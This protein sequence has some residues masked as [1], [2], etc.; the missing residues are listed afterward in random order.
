MKK[1]TLTLLILLAVVGIL[2]VF[3]WNRYNALVS[4]QE[5]MNNAWAQ[6]ES[7]YQRRLDLIPNLVSTVKGYATHE[8]QTL[9][10]VTEARSQA[11]QA[12]LSDTMSEEQMAA[13]Q[14]AQN[15]VSHS[16]K[17]VMEAYPELKANEN[18]RALQD[19]LAGTENRIAVARNTFN[20]Q[21]TAY[22]K[23][24][25][26]FPTNIVA[27]LFGFERKTLF[28][29]DPEAAQAPTVQFGNE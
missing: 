25:R 6:V 15:E 13:F 7:Q 18:F 10:Q 20:T 1:S 27:S 5:E 26:R 11:M 29:A 21:A 22:N 3:G 23:T 4:Y 24:L 12:P 17:M 8:S 9:L 14:T 2:F 16:I 28:Q 19:E